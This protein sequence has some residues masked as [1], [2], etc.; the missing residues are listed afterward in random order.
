[1]SLTRKPNPARNREQRR[2]DARKRR[3]RKATPVLH[4][5]ASERSYRAFLFRRVRL[6]REILND[7]LKPLFDDLS[8]GINERNKQDASARRLDDQHIDMT[9]FLNAVAGVEKGFNRRQVPSSAAISGQAKGVDR[10]ATN[11]QKKQLELFSSPETIA[12]VGVSLRKPA[13]ALRRA[14]V[15]ENVE[16]ITSIDKRFFDD[17]KS[18]MREGFEAGESTRSIRRRLQARYQVSRSRAQLIARD[19]IAK[20]NGDITKQR[21]TSAGVTR[22]RWSTSGDERVRATHRANNGKV[23]FWSKPPA[24]TGHPGNDFQCRCIAEPIFDD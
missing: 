14:W 16:L 13:T 21:Q 7:R 22:Y 2:E 5:N 9:R 15:K 19:Q 10:F 17:I 4:P 1:M 6:A 12:R 24:V 8:K 11:Q 20:L 18:T 23:F 3:I